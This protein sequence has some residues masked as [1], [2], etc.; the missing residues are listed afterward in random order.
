MPPI[1]NAL[2][3]VSIHLCYPSFDSFN[4]DESLGVCVAFS[5]PKRKPSPKKSPNASMFA[6]KEPS[7]T[8]PFKSNVCVDAALYAMFFVIK[9]FLLLHLPS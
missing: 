8:P 6:I 7:K 4:C 2:F 1:M 3:F 5:I 9:K